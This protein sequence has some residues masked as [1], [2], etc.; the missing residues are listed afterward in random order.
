MQY[1]GTSDKGK[2]SRLEDVVNLIIKFED[3]LYRTIE[4][5]MNEQVKYVITQEEWDDNFDKV[6]GR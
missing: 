4:E 3:N 6:R 5:Y 1:T 2:G